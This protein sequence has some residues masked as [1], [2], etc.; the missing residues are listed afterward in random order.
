MLKIYG[1]NTQ[2]NKKVL[3]I[4]EE[5]KIPYEFISVNLMERENRSKDFLEMNPIG[6]VPVIE[7]EGKYLFESGAI[8]RYLGDIS[9]SPLLPLDKFERAQVDQWMEFFTNHLGRFLN[10]LYFEK[11]LKPIFKI[12]EANVDSCNEAEKFSSI[13]LKVL[14]KELSKRSYI[15]SDEISLA[16]FYAYAYIEQMDVLK[17]SFDNFPNVLDWKERIRT[18][19][20]IS[21][22]QR[23]FN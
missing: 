15:A 19:D 17:M 14:D 21:R 2:N 11:I 10:T 12:G 5:L 4:A 7:H 20:S 18:R 8:C 22:A 6:K 1:F 13:Q 3:Y 23:H 16:D 9:N